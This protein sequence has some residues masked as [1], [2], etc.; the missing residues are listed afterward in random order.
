MKTTK[1]LSFLF[2]L[3]MGCMMVFGQA[4]NE[5]PKKVPTFEYI[6]LLKDNIFSDKD[7]AKKGQ[8]LFIYYTTECIHCQIAVQ[9]MN[10]NYEKFKNTNL[11]FV[12][13]YPK[14]KVLQFFDIY[15]ENFKNAKNVTLLLDSNDEFIF[16]FNPQSFPSFYLYDK[17]KNLVT[18]K[19]GSLEFRDLFSYLKK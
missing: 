4:N 5:I 16:N 15:G 13:T 3:L 14:D 2:A 6:N 19:K 1:Q 8:T 11:I 18:Y 7:L 10:D 17:D 12:S 9:H